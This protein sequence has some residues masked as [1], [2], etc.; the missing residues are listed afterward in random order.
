MGTYVVR[1]DSPDAPTLNG[2]AGSLL[3][4]LDFALI[5]GKVFTYD[6]T[7]YTDRTDDAR[8]GGGQSFPLFPSA[9]TSDICYFGYSGMVYSPTSDSFLPAFRELTFDLSTAGSGGAYAW[10]YWNGSSWVPLT[11]Q[12]DTNGFTQSGKVSWAPPS[13]W[14]T[15][16]VNGYTT[17]WVRVRPTS[18][19]STAPQCLSVTACG[20][21][22]AFQGPN[23]AAYMQGPWTGAVPRPRYLLRVLDNG[24]VSDAREASWI[25]YEAM[26]DV[27]TGTNRFPSESQAP[28]GLCVRKSDALDA[29]A[30]RWIVVADHRTFVLFI[31]RYGYSYGPSPAWNGPYVFGDYVPTDPNYAYPCMVRAKPSFETNTDEPGQLHTDSGT[32]P[33]FDYSARDYSGANISAPGRSYSTHLCG[34][35]AQTVAPGNN[36]TSGRAFLSGVNPSDG[37]VWVAPVWLTDYGSRAILGQFRGLWVP[38]ALRTAFSDGVVHRGGGSYSG[39]ALQFVTPVR[40]ADTNSALYHAGAW[41]VEVSDTW[42]A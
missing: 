29:T 21:L 18:A 31:E 5:I 22:R 3:Q 17:Y 37:R 38:L 13:N 1:H 36:D 11:V 33:T 19:P 41:Y 6:G 35:A 32:A 40:G 24:S 4:V 14:A 42:D 26:S 10:E 8:L 34:S 2:T 25:G 27:D 7:N 23:K 15:T 30:R 9:S 39:R 20:W 16:T 12:D 28:S